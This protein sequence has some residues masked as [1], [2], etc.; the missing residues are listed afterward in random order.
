MFIDIFYMVIP[1]DGE[2]NISSFIYD[3]ATNIPNLAVRN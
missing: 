3:Y 1:G 2:H